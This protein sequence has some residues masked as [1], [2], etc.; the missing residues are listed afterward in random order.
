MDELDAYNPWSRTDEIDEAGD[1]L[2]PDPAPRFLALAPDRHMRRVLR[3]SSELIDDAD[4]VDWPE[5]FDS[6]SAL[7][8]IHSYA[9]VLQRMVA[10][11]MAEHEQREHKARGGKNN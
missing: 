3:W 1:R 8:R 2:D 11:E 10:Q 4:L 5:A 9:S 6:L 7:A